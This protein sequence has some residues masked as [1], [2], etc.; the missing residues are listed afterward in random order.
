MKREVLKILYKVSNKMRHF[1]QNGF[2]KCV[3]VIGHKFA[4][5][6]INDS[7]LMQPIIFMYFE[8]RK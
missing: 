3:E 7:F 1:S 4:K 2:K 6:L 5:I 8:K